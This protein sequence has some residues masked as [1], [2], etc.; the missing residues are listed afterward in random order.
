MVTRKD[1]GMGEYLFSLRLLDL[2]FKK[3]YLISVGVICQVVCLKISRL[4][5]TSKYYCCHRWHSC[6][7][8]TPTGSTRAILS[9]NQGY[10]KDKRHSFNVQVACDP[11]RNIVD[12]FTGNPGSMHDSRVFRR[13]SLYRR[14]LYGSILNGDSVYFNNRVIP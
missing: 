7:Y 11:G 2:K 5:W 1:D 9:I 13:S 14:Y 8:L 4:V 10:D 3:C 6:G 12:L